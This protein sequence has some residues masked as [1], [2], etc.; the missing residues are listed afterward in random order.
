MERVERRPGHH[1]RQQARRRSCRRSGTRSGSSFR[2]LVVRQSRPILL[3]EFRKLSRCP[4]LH[5]GIATHLEVLLALWGD[6]CGGPRASGQA[7]PAEIVPAPARLPR[8]A[9]VAVAVGNARAERELSLDG[10]GEI[11][12]PVPASP[13]TVASEVRLGMMVMRMMVVRLLVVFAFAITLLR[14]KQPN[15]NEGLVISEVPAF[16]LRYTIPTTTERLVLSQSKSKSF[17]GS[18][19]SRGTY[20]ADQEGI[21]GGLYQVASGG[22]AVATDV[23]KPVD[24]SA[25][26]VPGS[27]IHGRLQLDEIAVAAIVVARTVVMVAPGR[28]KD[29]GAG[30]GRV[31]A[32][33]QAGARSFPRRRPHCPVALP[34]LLAPASLP[35][36]RPIPLFGIQGYQRI[37]HAGRLLRYPHS[38]LWV[39]PNEKK[40][41]VESVRILGWN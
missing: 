14:N 40:T 34:G 37:R 26:R 1:L 19:G 41:L 4:M 33:L 17:N 3:E 38:R 35:G 20:R 39:V 23:A 24:G 30:G 21:K 15:V 12:G 9:P 18:R 11:D 27:R 8:G 32:A 36:A 29:P 10:G 22:V 31:V 2:R 6:G 16:T 7:D 25:S 13:R 28:L 5:E